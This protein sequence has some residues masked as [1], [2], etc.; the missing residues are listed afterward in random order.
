MRKTCVCVCVCVCVCER[1]RERERER[2]KV[3]MQIL[4]RTT[5][6]CPMYHVLVEIDKFD[7]SAP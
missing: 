7:I 5:W 4:V 1:E 3:R 2:E 6:I